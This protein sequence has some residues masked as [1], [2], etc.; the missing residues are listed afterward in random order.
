[1]VTALLVGI[2]AGAVYTP[3]LEM[4]PAPV[5]VQFTAGFA[6]PLTFGDMATLTPNSAVPVLVPSASVA[7]RVIELEAT[8]SV[9]VVPGP[10]PGVGFWTCRLKV[11][12]ALP[13][14]GTWTVASL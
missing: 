14:T 10:P 1:M 5:T 13:A 2:F 4:E 12:V 8:L 7:V 3:A 11:P 9:N 6:T